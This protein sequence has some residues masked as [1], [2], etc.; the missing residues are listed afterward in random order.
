MWSHLSSY[1]TTLKLRWEST[2]KNSNSIKHK[3]SWIII[4]SVPICISG[5]LQ[6]PHIDFNLKLGFAIYK[7]LGPLSLAFNRNLAQKKHLWRGSN[8]TPALKW[9]LCTSEWWLLIPEARENSRKCLLIW[10]ESLSFSALD[11]L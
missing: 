4:G 7:N 8:I 3:R 1:N 10:C 11:S 9:Q 2:T 6:Y 5:Y